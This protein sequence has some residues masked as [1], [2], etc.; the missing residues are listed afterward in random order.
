MPITPVGKPKLSAAEHHDHHLLDC[1]H[2]APLNTLWS[3]KLMSLPIMCHDFSDLQNLVLHTLWKQP[4]SLSKPHEQKHLSLIQEQNCMFTGPRNFVDCFKTKQTLK[5]QKLG[6]NL[7]FR[8]GWFQ[9]SH[10]YGSSKTLFSESLFTGYQKYIP[11]TSLCS[12][13]HIF[14]RLPEHVFSK[15]KNKKIFSLLQ[16]KS[17]DHIRLN[18]RKKSLERI[19]ET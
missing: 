5:K 3:K 10:I 13:C 17:S 2:H 12:I 16:S 18:C 15:N 11:Q 1:L 6:S 7:C 14:L 19:Q 8:F 4:G 9:L